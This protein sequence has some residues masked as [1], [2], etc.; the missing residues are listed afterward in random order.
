[1]FLKEFTK[2]LAVFKTL[3]DLDPYFFKKFGFDKSQLM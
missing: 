2:G 3:Q 1:M